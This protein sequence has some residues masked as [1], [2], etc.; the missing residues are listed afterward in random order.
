MSVADKTN[1][2]LHFAKDDSQFLIVPFENVFRDRV[3]RAAVDEK[4][5]LQD[6]RCLQTAEPVAGAGG[7]EPLGEH[8][9]LSGSIIEPLEEI[10]PC[11]RQ[12][13]IAHYRWNPTGSQKLDYLFRIR[14]IAND[15]AQANHRI[16]ARS[17]SIGKDPGKCL[18]VSVNIGN[19]GNFHLTLEEAPGRSVCWGKISRKVVPFPGE[20]STSIR[21]PCFSIICLDILRPIPVPSDFRVKK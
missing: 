15:V 1:P 16:G 3:R 2:R 14:A 4:S 7:D 21:A 5:V 8:Q 20:E 18:K 17:I 10:R 9:G 11:Q 12:F 6:H 19:N 13:M